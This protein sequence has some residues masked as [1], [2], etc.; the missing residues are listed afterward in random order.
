MRR[1][2]TVLIV[3]GMIF[4]AIPAL[5]AQARLDIGA[6]IPRGSGIA[7]GGNS[8]TNYGTAIGNWPFIPIPDAGIYYQGDLGMVKLG[9]GARAFS[10]IIET[11]AWPNAYAELDLGKFAIEAQFGG[12][13]FLM[14]GIAPTQ[15]SFGNSFIPDISAW[16]K[17]GKQGAFRLG[18][19]LIGL[20]LPD[21]LGDTLPFL[22]YLGGKAS[23]ML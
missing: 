15:A 17:L 18:G 10:L 5:T 19:G 3:I 16:F 12:G 1:R 21:I 8:A 20:Y 11:I 14:F 6:V 23:L 2:L 9:I 4:A 13:A 7:I 22:F